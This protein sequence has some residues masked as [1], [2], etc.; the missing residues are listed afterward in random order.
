MNDLRILVPPSDAGAVGGE[1]E[2]VTRRLGGGREVCRRGGATRVDAPHSSPRAPRPKQISLHSRQG[3]RRARVPREG[4]GSAGAAIEPGPDGMAPRLHSAS[5]T[6]TGSEYESAVE[7]ADTLLVCS[8]RSSFGAAV[9]PGAAVDA[10][11][12]VVVGDVNVG[13]VNHAALHRATVANATAPGAQAPGLAPPPPVGNEPAQSGSAGGVAAGERALGGSYEPTEEPIIVP[14]RLSVSYSDPVRVSRAMAFGRVSSETAIEQ[15]A[16]APQSDQQHTR[17]RRGTV[18]Y[19]RQPA[20]RITVQAYFGIGG[21]V[22]RSKNS[23]RKSLGLPVDESAPPPPTGAGRRG[24]S[25]AFEHFLSSSWNDVVGEGATG[26][27]KTNEQRAE[28]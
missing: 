19:L 24:F 5:S 1:R 9:D 18:G 28:T 13:T 2:G 20:R 27:V 25:A 11:A 8:Q 21:A 23:L 22:R 15:T 3:C 12:A 10:G 4:R 16:R 7:D 6:S 26:E 14:H 17:A